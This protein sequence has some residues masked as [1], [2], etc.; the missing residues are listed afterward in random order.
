ML[1]HSNDEDSSPCTFSVCK[2]DDDICLVR[3]SLAFL[4]FPTSSYHTVIL[5]R[6]FLSYCHTGEKLHFV[7]IFLSYYLLDLFEFSTAEPFKLHL[8]I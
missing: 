8:Q 3:N 4:G 6:L 7:K 2:A 1:T 5:V